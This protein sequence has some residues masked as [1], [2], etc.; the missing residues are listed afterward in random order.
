M[1]RAARRSGYRRRGAR[2]DR[3]AGLNY[4]GEG[5]MAALLTTANRLSWMTLV[6]LLAGCTAIPDNNQVSLPVPQAATQAGMQAAEE[7]EHLR[8]LASYGGIYENAKLQA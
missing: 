7:R 2:T 4:S 1:D 8:I 5:A 6:L 3:T